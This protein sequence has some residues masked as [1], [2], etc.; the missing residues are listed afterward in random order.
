MVVQNKHILPPNV[1]EKPL[2]TII[3]VAENA[4]LKFQHFEIAQKIEDLA[5]SYGNNALESLESFSTSEAKRCLKNLVRHLM[6]LRN[7]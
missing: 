7:K 5:K 4:R 2:N 3:P 1:L 6:L